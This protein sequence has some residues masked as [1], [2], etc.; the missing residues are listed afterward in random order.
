MATGLT[1]TY[2]TTKVSNFAHGSLATVGAYT[3]FTLFHAFALSPYT[4]APVSFIVT[5]AANL[6]IYH[7]AVNP[8]SKKSQNTVAL[9]IATLAADI[10]LIGIFGIYSD[11]LNTSYHIID[12]KYFSLGYLDISIFGV[13]GLAIVGPALVVVIALLIHLFLT[14]TKF[15]TAMRGTVENKNLALVFGINTRRVNNVAWFLSGG[16][17]GL[18]GSLILFWVPG[19]PNVGDGLLPAIFAASLLGGLFSIYGALIGGVI[20]GAAQI[21]VT[22]LLANV[23]GSWILGFGIGV[24][25]VLM[26]VTLLFIPFGVT[27]IDWGF[28]KIGRKTKKW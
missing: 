14:K 9:M 10:A 6:G 1:L 5:G 24:P 12:S 7:L 25:I 16:L 23:F 17:A 11:L 4:S 19:N 13:Q 22:S 3:S 2:M 21:P 27:S 18:A 28:L 26:V 20:V 8:V 15:G